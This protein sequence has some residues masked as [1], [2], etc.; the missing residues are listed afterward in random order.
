MVTYLEATNHVGRRNSYSY[1]NVPL[2]TIN[3]LSSLVNGRLEG[4]YNRFEGH[5]A[6]SYH[7]EIKSDFDK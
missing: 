2:S 3:T 4:R 1:L 5:E 6:Y 7:V